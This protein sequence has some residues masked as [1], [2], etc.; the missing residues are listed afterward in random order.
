MYLHVWPQTFDTALATDEA[1]LTLNAERESRQ[2]CN[3]C[4]L[5]DRQHWTQT[6]Q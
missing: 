3:G 4:D 2:P 1:T 5:V 6:A